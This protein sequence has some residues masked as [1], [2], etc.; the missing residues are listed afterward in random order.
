ME[1]QQSTT[2]ERILVEAKQEF[3]E[4]GYQ[5]ASLRNIV[6]KAGV[7]TG[8]L[9]GYFKNKEELFEALVGES[10]HKILDMYYQ[11]LQSF[12]RLSPEEQMQNMEAMTRRNVAAMTDYIYSHFDS[13]KLI[14]CCSDG[15]K[16][17]DIVQQMVS[18][19]VDATHMFAQNSQ[20]LRVPV[21]P[22][23]P[24]LE[25]MLISGMFTTY[26][27]LVVYDVP[28]EEAAAYTDQL[29]TFHVAGWEK[30]MGFS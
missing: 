24:M 2:L 15:T 26:F 17:S 18:M 8:A 23:N 12:F 3:L 22:V 14:L 21:S 1:E 10:Y 20:Q 7:T 4:K 29:L 5:R 27:Q 11:V 13:F 6:K 25:Q 19:D 28:Q 30:I 9:Y 16:Y